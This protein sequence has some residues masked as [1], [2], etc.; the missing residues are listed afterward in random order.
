VPP[1]YDDR[2]AVTPNDRDF[3]PMG[4]AVAAAAFTRW[5]GLRLTYIVAAVVATLAAGF[6]AAWVVGPWVGLGVMIAV[7]LLFIALPWPRRPRARE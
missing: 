6:A 2:H 1:I 4:W 3:T 5:L 7:A